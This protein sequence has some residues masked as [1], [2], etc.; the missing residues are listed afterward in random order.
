MKPQMTDSEK[1]ENEK[2]GSMDDLDE[3]LTYPETYKKIRTELDEVI[4]KLKEFKVDIKQIEKNYRH[5][6]NYLNKRK[7][8]RRNSD[9]PTGFNKPRLIPDKMAD[10]IGVKHGT[11]MSGPEYTKN[12]YQYLNDKNLYG[13]S[14]K[15]FRVNDA[16]KETFNLTK[17]QVNKMN[18]SND[19]RD[20]D[21]L[22]FTTIQ[23]YFSKEFNK[24]KKM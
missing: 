23:R 2:V 10:L 20:P 11:E 17:E 12:F 24:L 7:K 8:H 15:V 14:K 6:M 4:N 13:E 18:K 19:D 9:K 5:D 1:V 21:G 22:N 16:I 3:N